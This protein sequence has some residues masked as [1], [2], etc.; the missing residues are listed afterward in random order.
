VSSN[1]PRYPKIRPIYSFGF[2]RL[3]DLSA[4]KPELSLTLSVGL[5]LGMIAETYNYN[6]V[7]H[8]DVSVPPGTEPLP[9]AFLDTFFG[10]FGKTS[11]RDVLRILENGA[12]SFPNERKLHRETRTPIANCK[13]KPNTEP[14][15]QRQP[16]IHRLRQEIRHVL[17]RRSDRLD[18]GNY[19]CGQPV[20]RFHWIRA[21]LYLLSRANK[22]NLNIILRLRGLRGV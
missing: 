10:R 20:V 1:R 18:P 17:A 14:I 7:R 2:G 6:K 12:A 9:Y 19:S 21:I 5:F 4:Q 8:A 22:A 16:A 3:C 15:V 11:R 13:M